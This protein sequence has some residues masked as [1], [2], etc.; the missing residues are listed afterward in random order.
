MNARME[1]DPATE[2]GVLRLEFPDFL[3]RDFPGMYPAAWAATQ[4]VLK[5]IPGTD[6][7]SLERHSPALKGFDW[8]NYIRLSAIRLVRAGALLERVGKRSGRLL[9]YGAYFGNFS[10]FAAKMGFDVTAADGYAAYGDA[11][12][13]NRSLLEEAG[14]DVLEFDA[15]GYDL[16]AVPAESFDVVL[17]MGVIEHIPHTPRPVLEA[18][19]RVLKPGGVLLLDTPNLCYLYNHDRLSRGESIFTP[20]QSQYHTEIPFEGHHR[21]YTPDEVRYMLS[22]IGHES[23]I[24][25]T[26]NYSIYWLSEISGNDLCMYRRMDFNENVREIIMTASAKA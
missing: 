11:F 15:V 20:I 6:Y 26:F 13:Q 9:D 2:S 3:A 21:E 7:T 10:L 19:N 25:E 1:P 8:S 24:L 12:S 23:V 5:A 18:V 14:V 4:A 16:G 17:C 22:Q